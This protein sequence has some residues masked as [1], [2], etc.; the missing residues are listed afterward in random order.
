M[1][2]VFLFILDSIAVVEVL[3]AI[4][5]VASTTRLLNFDLIEYIVLP[6]LLL[7]YL[8]YLVWLG[9]FIYLGYR[10]RKAPEIDRKGSRVAKVLTA[11]IAITILN[12]FVGK[13]L[14]SFM[15][16]F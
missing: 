13:E 7:G 4:L 10:F 2:K 6:V 5:F 3:Q 8:N 11:A 16:S 14:V 1:K 12:A 9:T 15:A